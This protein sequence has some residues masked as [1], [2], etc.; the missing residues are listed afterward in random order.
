MEMMGVLDDEAGYHHVLLSVCRGYLAGWIRTDVALNGLYASPGI[1]DSKI[2]GRIDSPCPV[3]APTFQSVQKR[4]I[5]MAQTADMGIT[6]QAGETSYQVGEMPKVVFRFLVFYPVAPGP[7]RIRRD[8]I[9]DL[10]QGA[11]AA[12]SK[13]QGI[14]LL[15]FFRGGEKSIAQ[16]LSPQ[17]HQGGDGFFTAQI[18]SFHHAIPEVRSFDLPSNLKMKQRP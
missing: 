3:E 16:G 10:N 1:S 13:S 8:R 9:A 18:T 5:Q 2:S 14:D 7:E 12:L 4:V 17:V 11:L 15:I 6:G